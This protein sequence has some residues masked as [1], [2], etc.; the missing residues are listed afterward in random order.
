[1]MKKMELQNPTSHTRREK[2]TTKHVCDRCEKD[3]FGY[4]S[5]YNS[6]KF[7]HF[8]HDDRDHYGPH[9][10]DKDLCDKCIEELIKFLEEPELK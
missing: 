1:M 3:I 8:E 7:K 6:I 4:S 10:F 5:E 2:M 9:S